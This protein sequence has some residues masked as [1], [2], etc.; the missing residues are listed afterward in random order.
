MEMSPNTA[1]YAWKF[2]STGHRNT[3]PDIMAR[4][5]LKD[6][7][8]IWI[9]GTTQNKANSPMNTMTMV[10]ITLS[11]GFRITRAPSLARR[12]LAGLLFWK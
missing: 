7:A 3:S 2:Q 5:P 10:S 6:K 9:I 8:K 11:T 1:E 12:C 4:L